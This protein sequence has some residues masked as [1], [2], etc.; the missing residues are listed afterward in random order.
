MP[1]NQF[2]HL[3]VKTP[4][5]TPFVTKSKMIITSTTIE[6]TNCALTPKLPKLIEYV[7]V[8]QLARPLGMMEK[9]LSNQFGKRPTS[10]E[11][12]PGVSP[13]RKSRRS[14]HH[15]GRSDK[16]QTMSSDDEDKELPGRSTLSE[17]MPRTS[18][19]GGVGATE[20]EHQYEGDEDD[21]F[22]VSGKILIS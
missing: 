2:A 4:S 16:Y 10:P 12:D 1:C 21:T 11:T 18:T 22:S 14:R 8:P 15:S 9:V 19:G 7:F 5:S 3:H 17:P 13:G 20:R 6:A